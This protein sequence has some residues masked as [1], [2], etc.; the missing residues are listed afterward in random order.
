MS[1]LKWTGA[2]AI[3]RAYIRVNVTTQCRSNAPQVTA[4]VKTCLC[5]IVYMLFERRIII[6]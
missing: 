4:V 5:K 3:V 6:E 1:S 2:V